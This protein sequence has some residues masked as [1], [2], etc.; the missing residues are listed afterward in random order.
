MRVHPYTIGVAFLVAAAVS[1]NAQQR[2]PRWGTSS[3]PSAQH[4]IPSAPPQASAALTIYWS[5][6]Y[7]GAQFASGGVGLRNRGIGV[8]GISAAVSPIKAAWVYWAVITDGK[9]TKEN[10]EITIKRLFPVPTKSNMKTASVVL[11]GFPVGTA[12]TTPCWLGNT[13][14]VYRAE[15]SPN[16]ATG[17]GLYEVSTVSG[18]SGGEDPWL[19]SPLPEL[20]GASLV[21]IGQGSATVARYDQMISGKGANLSGHEFNADPGFSYDL[22]LPTLPKGANISSATQVLFLNI[23]ADGQSVLQS[24]TDN[25]GISDKVTTINKMQVAGPPGVGGTL[26]NVPDWD[27][28]VAGPL[29][30]LWDDNTHDITSVIQGGGNISSLPVSIAGGTDAQGGSDCL[31]TVANVLAITAQSGSSP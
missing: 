25:S 26:D 19:V 4:G 30:Q 12:P 10:G 24:L 3:A 11:T 21:V 18:S 23:G 27:G 5:Q 6:I 16:L 9:P 7:E 15:V 17:N 20:E 22:T 13:T 1:A 2:D 8:I 29:P 28:A 14:T 31:V